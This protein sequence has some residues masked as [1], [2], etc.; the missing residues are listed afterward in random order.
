MLRW[1]LEVLLYSFFKLGARLVRGCDQR[2]AP[3]RA[4]AMKK[5]ARLFLVSNFSTSV[6]DTVLSGLIRVTI[7]EK[8]AIWRPRESFALLAISNE[9]RRHMLQMYCE[10]RLTCLL[11]RGYS[12]ESPGWVPLYPYQ[13]IALTISHTPAQASRHSVRTNVFAITKM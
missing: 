6:V 11:Y 1:G 3:C 9:L 8:V 13:A 7:C 2:H 4:F 5:A 10:I 12:T